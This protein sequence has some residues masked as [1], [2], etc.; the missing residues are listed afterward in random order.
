MHSYNFVCGHRKDNRRK[1][2]NT[3]L[4]GCCR[5]GIAILLFYW[6]GIALVY[7][8][9]VV[10][11]STPKNGA[12]LLQPPQEII[13]HFNAKIEKTL[14]KVS[15]KTSDGKMVLLPNEAINKRDTAE[16]PDYLII[17]LPLLEPGT[18][19]LQYKVL[20]ID[21][22]A[23]LGELRFTISERALP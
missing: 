1:M 17:Q 16:T 11:E 14:A 18:Y 15:L 12:I 23:T 3:I 4:Y 21:G 10:I 19:L 13:L 2:S 9:A 6:M 5:Q 8:H 22:H 7:A 20:A